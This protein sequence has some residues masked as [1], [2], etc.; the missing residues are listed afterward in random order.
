MQGCGDPQ[1]VASPVILFTRLNCFRRKSPVGGV[2]YHFFDKLL[3]LKTLPI[4]LDIVTL[5][6]VVLGFYL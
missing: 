5:A 4:F 6:F 2:L 1:R 3:L